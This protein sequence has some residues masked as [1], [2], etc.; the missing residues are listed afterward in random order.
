MECSLGVTGRR[1]SV[2]TQ[3]ESKA[4]IGGGGQIWGGGGSILLY[5]CLPSLNHPHF[6]PT[7]GRGGAFQSSD[8]LAPLKN[9]SCFLLHAGVSV[10]KDWGEGGRQ[11]SS[12]SQANGA[13]R[14][15]SPPPCSLGQAGWV[16]QGTGAQRPPDLGG[17]TLGTCLRWITWQY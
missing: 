5:C 2:V 15:F 8:W 3:G 12:P 17:Q 9:A 16:C 13:E 6:F 10:E 14:C 11:C 4:E 7:R 1:E